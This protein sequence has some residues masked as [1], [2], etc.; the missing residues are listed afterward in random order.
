M[1]IQIFKENGWEIRTVTKDGEPWFVGKDVCESF[2]DTNYKRSLNKVADED[3]GV[4]H[5]DTPGGKQG[6]TIINESGLYSLLFSMQPQKSTKSQVPAIKDRQIALK[7]FKRWVTHE[8]LPSIR[9]HGGYIHTKPEDSPE[10]IMAKAIKLADA[11]I[12]QLETTVSKA[13][14]AID[15]RNYATNNGTQWTITDAKNEL[16]ISLADLQERL[17][18]VGFFRI[19]KMVKNN[20]LWPKD[21][22]IDCGYCVEIQDGPNYAFTVKGMRFLNTLVYDGIVRAEAMFENDRQPDLFEGDE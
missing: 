18:V 16:E 10:M 11:K 8:V 19:R 15:F 4:S 9:K 7:Q 12:K 1:D 5:I 14:P 22:Y 2:G 17:A 3:K 13:A 6:M 21:K 20:R